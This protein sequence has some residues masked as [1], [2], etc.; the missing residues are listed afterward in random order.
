[1]TRRST[2]RLMVALISCLLAV[3]T[4]VLIGRAAVV[5]LVTPWFAL[6]AL[7]LTSARRQEPQLS[8]A[9]DNDRVMVNDPVEVTA[10]VSGATGRVTMTYDPVWRFGAPTDRAPIPP[11]ADVTRPG[12]DGS[13]AVGSS[14]ESWAPPAVSTT[15]SIPAH[16]WGMFD[17][18][19][20]RVEVI[21]PYGL[22]RWTGRLI[23]PCPIRVH[24]TP[25]Q[26]TNMVGPRFVRQTTGAHRSRSVDRGV[27]YADIR[28]YGPGDSLRDINWRVSARAQELWVSQRHPDRATDVVL[29]L[30][31]FIES[32]HDVATVVGLAVEAAV[33]VAE[34]HLA[35]TDQVG[36]VEMGGLVRWV[37]PGTGA[38]QLQRLV[39]TLLATGLYASSANRDLALI[40]P[41]ALPP[42][43]LVIAL[44][45][46][47]D[48]RFLDALHALAARG[49]DL[50]VIECDP[51]GRPPAADHGGRG[52][53]EPSLSRLGWR[54]WQ[55][56]REVTRD[57]LMERNVAVARWD[58]GQPI[59][60][61]LQELIRRRARVGAMS[62]GP[63]AGVSGRPG[64]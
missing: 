43:S 22:L 12:R 29:V 31:S 11:V 14:R 17:V 39:D 53:G 24:P 9:V 2:E 21:E 48:E 32:G 7:G 42:R 19:R 4:A 18:G 30:D 51:T 52:G 58:P 10:T 35:V 33:A 36:L 34:S 40:S 16:Q 50:A 63:V 49:H 23:D 54:L 37:V 13:G 3:A 15:V 45:P 62:A 64:R 25:R 41:R 59:D 46:L 20:V 8:V 56:E 57:Q 1:M 28:P 44:S 6:L 60:V 38:L 55:A 26:I 27:E 5:M 61:A 47:L